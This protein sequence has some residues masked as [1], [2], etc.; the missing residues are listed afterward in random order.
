MP[1]PM[2]QFNPKLKIWQNDKNKF[3]N[4]GCDKN[5]SPIYK[6]LL[7]HHSTG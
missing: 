2:A 4:N 1:I 5:I 6:L 7:V 3:K